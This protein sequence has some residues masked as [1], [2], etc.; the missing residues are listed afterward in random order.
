[1]SNILMELFQKVRSLRS[2]RASEAGEL[3]YE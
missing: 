1:M 3:E 2:Q